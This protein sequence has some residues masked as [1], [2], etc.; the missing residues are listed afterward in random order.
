MCV[1][2]CVCVCLCVCML[3]MSRLV[4]AP[5]V[6]TIS[7]GVGFI[8][9]SCVFACQACPTIYYLNFQISLSF[10]DMLFVLHDMHIVFSFV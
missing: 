7:A 9:S 4:I 10:F 5:R 1:C 8:F 3:E 2:V 6:L